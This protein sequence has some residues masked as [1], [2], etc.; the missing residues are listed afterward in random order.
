MR[1]SLAALSLLACAILPGQA[2]DRLIRVNGDALVEA[3][4][5]YAVIRL[6]LEAKDRLLR[7]VRT[8]HESD[9]NA[10]LQVASKYK[11]PPADIAK[12][13]PEIESR[14]DGFLLRRTVQFTLHDLQSYD[15]MLFA[16][17]DSAAVT[18][19]AVEFR[20]NNLRTLRDRART[21]AVQ[22]AEEKVNMI[23]AAM[24][25]RVGRV[26]DVRVETGG[27][28]LVRRRGGEQGRSFLAAQNVSLSNGDGDTPGAGAELF[29]VPITAKVDVEY[30]ILE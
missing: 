1:N 25:R 19:E 29:R 6:N 3:K 18:I 12:D 8:M 24:K 9:L 20:V 22:A 28:V 27:G 13:F 23:A 14:A 5:D 7:R 21:M 30:E 17:Y 26:A 10:V 16:L 4:P 11:I 15:E 2:A